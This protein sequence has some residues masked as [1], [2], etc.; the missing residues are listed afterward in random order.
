M[1]TLGLSMID[2][3]APLH[4]YKVSG[5]VYTATR[6]MICSSG[7]HIHAGFNLASTAKCNNEAMVAWTLMWASNASMYAGFWLGLT[8]HAEALAAVSSL[9]LLA[10]LATLKLAWVCLSGLQSHL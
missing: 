8:V 2:T 5:C 3:K 6:E 10:V 7:R 4:Q 9:L 1:D